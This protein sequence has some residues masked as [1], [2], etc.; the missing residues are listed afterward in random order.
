[1]SKIPGRVQFYAIDKFGKRRIFSF[2]VHSKEDAIN[3][4]TRMNQPKGFYLPNERI[5]S[6][7]PITNPYYSPNTTKGFLDRLDEFLRL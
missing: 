3:A 1:M 6:S 5:R 4:L 7:E 2:K